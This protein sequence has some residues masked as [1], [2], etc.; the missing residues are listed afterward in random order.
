LLTMILSLLD[1][2]KWYKKWMINKQNCYKLLKLLEVIIPNKLR[3]IIKARRKE[4]ESQSC[5]SLFLLLDHL[6]ESEIC[7]KLISKN[8][9][10]EDHQ[11]RKT[12]QKRKKRKI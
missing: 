5:R 11:L 3:P 8:R 6:R 4:R 12:V 7:L 9:L 1:L 10:V 2:F